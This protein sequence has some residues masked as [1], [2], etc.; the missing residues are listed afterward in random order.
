MASTTRSVAVG[1]FENKTDAQNAVE[2]LRRAG[3]R[4]DQIGVA[5]RSQNIQD[6]VRK[7]QTAGSDETHVEEGATIGAMSGAGVGALWGLAVAAG[8][9]PPL[10]PV[11]AG[12][13]L[14]AILASAVLGAAAGGLVGVLVGWGIPEDEARLY[15]EDLRAG[16]V[17]VAVRANGRS[18]EAISILRSCNARMEPYAVTHQ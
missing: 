11:I 7:A 2:E 18:Q 1:I 3:F 12:G 15:E 10:G 4:D 16:H 9:M 6:E 14:A 13:A 17:L 8:V 5:A